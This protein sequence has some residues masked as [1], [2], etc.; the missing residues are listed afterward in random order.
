MEVSWIV[1]WTNRLQP[2]EMLYSR[3]TFLQDHT[4]VYESSFKTIVFL[5]LYAEKTPLL[6][7][8]YEKSFVTIICKKK[9]LE[10]FLSVGLQNVHFT[11]SISHLDITRMY[12][13]G[14]YFR[15]SNAEG[16]E[17]VKYLKEAAILL[18]GKISQN[19]LNCTL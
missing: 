3:H 15:R 7:N 10:S 6:W 19:S 11:T 18:L 12:A 4:Y 1:G 17:L 13:S 8:H 2:I 14:E 9:S 5:P 16:N